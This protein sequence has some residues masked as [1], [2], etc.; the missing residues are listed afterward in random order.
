VECVTL[1]GHNGGPTLGAGRSWR[2]QCW[3][4]A[5]A[6]LLPHLPLEVVRLR[7]KR[8]AAIGL[9]YKTYAGFR[10]STGHDIVALLFSTNAL[11]MLRPGDALPEPRAV[12]LRAT[13]GLAH[14][15]AT[16]P[17]LDPVRVTAA[18]AA[19]GI[20]LG[21][22]HRAPAV[23]QSWSEIRGGIRAIL[24][25]QRLP[26]DR[27]LLIGDT[28]FEQEWTGAGGL[29]GYLPAPRYFPEAIA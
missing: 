19:E 9:D 28:H 6:D 4:R 10:A 22:C 11:R 12:K 26:G 15:V 27:V 24:A 2:Q 5:R 21:A 13:R 20:A 25:E 23:A 16:Q 8:A 18:L 1:I 14:L 29:A 17:P 7:V 3:R